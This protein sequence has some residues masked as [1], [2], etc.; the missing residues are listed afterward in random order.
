MWPEDITRGNGTKWDT[1]DT[2][3]DR[4]PSTHTKQADDERK[5]SETRKKFDIKDMKKE[6][7]QIDIW[8]KKSKL[9]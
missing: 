6:D 2:I 1:N 9:I 8:I 7:I 4:Q 3:S 5:I